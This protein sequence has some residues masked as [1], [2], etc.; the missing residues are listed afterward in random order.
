MRVE[1][2]DYHSGGDFGWNSTYWQELGAPWGGMF[3]TLE[4][5]AVICQM[6]LGEGAYGDV[7]LTSPR[8]VRAMTTN[9]LDDYPELPEP[10]RR[11]PLGAWAG[12]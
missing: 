3:S 11:T 2:P 1:T 4:D 10:I 6:L 9:R 8:T 5:F 7:R 12:S